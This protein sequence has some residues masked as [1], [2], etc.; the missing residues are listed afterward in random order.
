MMKVNTRF[1]KTINVTVP[2]GNKIGKIILAVIVL[3]FLLILAGTCWYTVDDREVGVVTTFGK[4]TAVSEAGVHL[5]LPF[6]M[7]KVTKAPVNAIYKIELGYRTN[8]QTGVTEVVENE[9]KMI[10][11]DYN[12]VNVD[13]FIEYKI[14]DPVKYLFDSREPDQILRMLA[15]SQI[16]SVISSYRIDDILTTGKSEIQ[17]RVKDM[18]LRELEVYDIGLGIVDVRIQDSEPPTVEVNDAFK[19]VETAKQGM[20]TALNNAVAY[21]NERLPLARSKEDELLRQAEVSKQA[22]INEAEKEVAMFEAM[23]SEY[24]MNPSV[25]RMRMYYEMIEEVLPGV[26]VFIDTSDG[27]VTKL[28]PLDSLM[29]TGN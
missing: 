11:G 5:K 17:M 1:G 7:Q 22:R 26:K 2:N 28:L 16:R 14:T 27:D 29:G 12:I 21:E 13:F 20:D 6:G 18:V 10:T 8:E 4:V 19:A 15:Q 9:S 23:Y 25:T 24:S 3:I